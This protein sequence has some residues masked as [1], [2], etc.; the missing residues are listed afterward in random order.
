M[1]TYRPFLPGT[2]LQAFSYIH[3]VESPS[4]LFVRKAFHSK[5]FLPRTITL[6]NSPTWCNSPKYY[7]FI[8]F[9]SKV[10][11]F[12]LSFQLPPLIF[13]SHSVTLYLDGQLGLVVG[14]LKKKKK[15]ANIVRFLYLT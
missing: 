10:S 8:L 7:N 14:D 6:C 15:K 9:K 3:R 4:Y 12:I 13:L 11:I 1:Q 5:N 2:I